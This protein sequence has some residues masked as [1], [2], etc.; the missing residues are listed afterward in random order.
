MS[1]MELDLEV[2]SFGRVKLALASQRREAYFE[3]LQF[4]LKAPIYAK[5]NI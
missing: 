5:S 3:Y 2:G 1:R 4:D